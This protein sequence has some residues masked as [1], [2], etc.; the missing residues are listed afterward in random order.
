MFFFKNKIGRFLFIVGFICIGTLGTRIQT[1]YGCFIWAD[2]DGSVTCVT[3]GV[4]LQDIYNAIDGALTGAAKS[5][6]AQIMQ[7]QIM[8]QVGGGKGGQPLF[9]TNFRTALIADPTQVAKQ[10][11]NDFLLSKGGGRG[12]S[13]NYVSL[14][15]AGNKVSQF[16]GSSVKSSGTAV[17]DGGNHTYKFDGYNADGTWKYKEIQTPIP[18]SPGNPGASSFDVSGVTATGTATQNFEIIRGQTKPANSNANWINQELPL[19]PS[20]ADITKGAK[21]YLGGSGCQVNPYDAQGTALSILS[22]TTASGGCNMPI[23]LGIA[24]AEVFADELAKN[25]DVA[26]TQAIAN[27]GYSSKTDASGNVQTPGVS[28]KGL[29]DA[30]SSLPNS[31][32]AAGK[33]AAERAGIAAGSLATAAINGLIN[34]GIAKAT[35]A[36]NGVL[37][38]ATGGMVS[39]GVSGSA[40]DVSKRAIPT[41][42]TT[43]ANV[44]QSG[45][46]TEYLWDEPHTPP[47]AAGKSGLSTTPL[48]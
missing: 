28:I 46:S 25:Q 8:L 22:A 6:L 45:L 37:G 39:I 4:V 1:S 33:N 35:N 13:L 47:A 17:R 32:A 3:Y 12:S 31:L 21:A 7:K 10:S 29:V 20:I 38:K 24:A 43:P 19:V 15:Q 2:L 41:A 9:I 14:S 5:A 27:Q 42:N 18:N 34:Q 48:W 11:V 23:G 36:V 30:A 26:K 40:V 16:F 44:S